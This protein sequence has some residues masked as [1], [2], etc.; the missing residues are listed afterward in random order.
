MWDRELACC[1]AD[2]LD[3]WLM[4][5]R[6]VSAVQAKYG[7]SKSIYSHCIQDANGHHPILKNDTVVLLCLHLSSTT[8]ILPTCFI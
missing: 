2:E 5:N 1:I 3:E 6:I 8:L 4:P 7:S